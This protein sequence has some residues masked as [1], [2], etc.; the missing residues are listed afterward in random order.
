MGRLVL[1]DFGTAVNG[2]Q[3][4]TVDAQ[5]EVFRSPEVMLKMKWAYPIDIWNVGCMVRPF[6]LSIYG[7][8]IANIG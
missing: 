3:V 4:W 2:D 7:F 6:Y 1:G 8:E 5:P